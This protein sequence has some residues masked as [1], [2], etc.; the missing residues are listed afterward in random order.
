MNLIFFTKKLNPR[1][2][3]IVKHLFIE[4]LDYS[5]EFTID[6]NHFV[7]S[8]KIRIQYGSFQGVKP[9]SFLIPRHDFM[10]E[11]DIRSQ[12]ITFAT[13][14]QFPS[15]F[16][17]NN[18]EADLPF[19]FL[20]MAFYL[21]TRYEEYLPFEADKHGRFTANQSQAFKYNF[22]QQPLVDQWLI[23][24]NDQ[25]K[26]RFQFTPVKSKT[27]SYIPTID[28]D[29]GWAYLH[30][31][32][33][34]SFGAAMRDLLKGQFGNFSSRFAVLRGRQAD[35][36]FK[37]DFLNELHQANGLKAVYF[38]LFGAHGTYDKNTAPEHP[39]MH[40]LVRK[41]AKE[42]RIG[43]HPSYASNSDVNQLGKETNDLTSISGQTINISRQ[44]FLKLS[45]PET[46]RGLLSVGI[47]SDYTMGYAE[48][49]G[50]RASTC[51]PFLWYDLEN[52]EETKLT[53]YP[54]QVMDVTLKNYLGLSPEE[55]S[56]SCEKIIE[57]VR[58]VNG[59]LISIWHNSSFSSLMGW[60]GWQLMYESFVVSAS[61]KSGKENKAL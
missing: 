5:I 47:R 34:R 6:Y 44:H 61:E 11:T 13:D 40:Q 21:L 22:L 12:D 3:Y 32:S 7:A 58:A 56:E 55:A 42:N 36:Y 57:E 31:D 51:H 35:P 23:F 1:I 52:E 33:W 37:F 54:F 60:D 53:V 49:L 2:E 14:H 20:S 59:T 17:I 24:I 46:Y 38:F 27:Y 19:D 43:F 16:T 29:F 10:S 4:V 18:P 30:K 8:D 39:A 26:E 41:I 15:F 28:I 9:P 25:L 48:E 50:F 45:F